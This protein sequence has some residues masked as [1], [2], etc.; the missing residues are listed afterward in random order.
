MESKLSP[1]PKPELKEPSASIWPHIGLYVVQVIA[2]TAPP[3]PYRRPLFA[4]LIIGLGI[5]AHIY[6]HFTN[7]VA[8]AQPFTIAWSYYLAT[9]AKLLFSGPSGPEGRFWRIDGPKQEALREEYRPFSWKK[10]RWAFSLIANQRGVRWSHEVKNVHPPETKS[11]GRFVVLQVWKIVKYMLVA[12]LLFSLSRRLFFTRP[13]GS[14]GV[15]DSHAITLRHT[16]WRWSF[17]KALTFGATP[18]FMLSMQYAQLALITVAL[19]ISKPEVC[20]F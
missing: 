10:L 3:A 1:Y 16:D 8:L 5:Y 4:S 17:I 11:R 13:D 19:G 14:V 6:P 7:D 12:D 20:R 9:L 18:Y 2:L 15:L